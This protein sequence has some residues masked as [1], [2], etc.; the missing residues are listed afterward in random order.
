MD[1]IDNDPA[2]DANVGRLMSAIGMFRL[3]KSADRLL[4]YVE[5]TKTRQAAFEALR[6]IS[7]FD[8]P[9]QDGDDR[10]P[11]QVVLQRRSR[12]KPPLDWEQKQHPRHNQVLARTVQAAYRLAHDAML[13]R[14]LPSVQ[15]ARGPE[16][17]DV[18][19]S[20][21]AATADKVRDRAVTALGFR[22]RE[23]SAKPDPLIA[24]LGHANLRTQLLAAEALAWAGRSEGI[25]V[26]MTAV[27]MMEDLN[28][29]RRA[30]RALGELADGAAL[31]VLL[32]L[33]NEEG[34][35]LQEDAAEAI[36]HLSSTDK[37]EAIEKLL[38]RLAKGEGG[39]ALRAM[40]GL[41]WFGSEAGW[42][43][44]RERARDW[45]PHVRQQAI[46]LL[47]E[48][49][50][51]SSRDAI[52]YCIEHDDGYEVVQKAAESLRKLEGPD[53][54]EP[55]Y[56]L[57][58]SKFANLESTLLDRLQEK[59]DAG[60]IFEE[61]PKIQP[62]LR[63]VYFDPLVSILLSRDPL[64]VEAA[65]AQLTSPHEMVG[66][67][68]A[69][70]LG[71]AGKGAAKKHGKALEAAAKQAAE[72]WQAKRE[73]LVAARANMKKLEPFTERYAK[74]LWASGQ[75]GIAD[76]VIVQAAQ[77]PGDE[78]WCR[79]IRIEG[80]QILAR[81]GGGKNAAKVL[82]T[83]LGDTDA[84]VRSLAAS[85]IAA[86]A[87]KS[88]SAVVTSVV[89]DRASLDRLLATD[90][91]DTKTDK[92][93]REAA[94]SAHTQGVTLPHLVKRGDVK[95]LTEA[96]GNKDLP[97]VTRL[98]A[99]EALARIANEAA[100]KALIAFAKKKEVD[101]ELRKAAWRGLRRA[102]RYAARAA[103][104]VTS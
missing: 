10:D 48:S 58:R 97:D 90:T 24:G 94:F 27:D 52:V 42:K 16:V 44:I 13:S 87:P 21:C 101:E 75:L 26:L 36:G 9:I 2:G 32:R 59:G 19:A 47:A 37:A 102:R 76:A 18:L 34:H 39:V 104:E 86:V 3:P 64:P 17:D 88:T 50:D 53:S 31:D 23:R 78:P 38:L 56:V 5:E 84:R 71:R 92:A 72:A 28:D 103:G 8:Q 73:E 77:Q 80:M 100:Q 63:Q 25:R 41:R 89:D 4:G 93:L 14:L 61:L 6:V 95:G 20:L 12:P 1:R 69:S 85:G 33:V 66:A 81:G 45:Y 99:V 79:T 11:A 46:E 43:L 65:T 54:L 29:R 67:V 68:A 7:G 82:Q 60:R 98:G 74:M 55:D 83:A 15:W 51:P 49:K 40:T 35:A 57:L 62:S 30:V 70:V 96:M 22:V 91:T